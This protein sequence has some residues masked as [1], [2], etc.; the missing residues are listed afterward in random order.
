MEQFNQLPL[1]QKVGVLV[2]VMA[3]VAGLFYYALI[4]PLD[5]ERLN[6]EQQK[7]MMQNELTALQTATKEATSIDRTARLEELTGEKERFENMLP[8]SDE[9]VKFITGLSEIAKNAGLRIVRVQKD[10]PREQDYYL[11]IPIQ[12]SVRGTYREL[13]GFLRTVSEKDRRVVNIRNLTIERGRLVVEELLE[14]YERNRRE[15]T[16]DG[17]TLRSLSPL[18]RLMQLVR[19]NEEV[20]SRGVQLQAKFTA[21]VFTYTGQ[22]ASKEAAQRIRQQREAR[23]ERRRKLVLL[24]GGRSS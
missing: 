1:P 17:V 10:P 9:L 24:G 18:Q 8:K 19:A 16:P 3:L 12:M 6:V 22:P 23:R 4:I 21:F 13:I 7:Q 15:E 2:G 14:K 11:E 5:E 20:I